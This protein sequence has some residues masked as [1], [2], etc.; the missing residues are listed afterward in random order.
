MKSYFLMTFI[1]YKL[2][3]VLRGLDN[4]LFT[5]SLKCLA[6]ANDRGSIIRYGGIPES[7]KMILHC[8]GSPVSHYQ[9]QIRG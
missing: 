6:L 1:Q 7:A 3:L 5:R 2:L 9:V 8:D 4:E